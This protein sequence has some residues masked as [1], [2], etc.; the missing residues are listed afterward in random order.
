LSPD[1]RFIVA[2]TETTG[3]T[4]ADA[5]VELAWVELDAE[6]QVLDRQHSLIDP[7][8]P[9]SHGASGVHGITIDMVTEAPTLPEFFEHCYHSLLTGDVVFIA[10][11]A[12]FDLRYLGPYIPTLAIELC[13]LRLARKFFPGAE[14][15]KLSTLMYELGLVRG[16][17]HRADGDV[18]TTVDLLRKCVE[19][20]GMTLTELAES[21]AQPEVVEQMPF[22]KYKGR[23]MA[24]VPRDYF[25]WLLKQGGHIDRDLKFTIDTMMP[26]R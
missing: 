21:C 1:Y 2:D 4:P 3:P 19:A 23:R 22:G 26:H 15:H 12:Q 10:H 20:S 8:R 25:D 17:S 5:V 7:Q 13:T 6:M 24:D 11:N 18:D 9:I 16:T 14:N